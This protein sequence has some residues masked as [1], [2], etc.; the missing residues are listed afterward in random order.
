MCEYH[1]QSQNVNPN[2]TWLPKLFSNG[3]FL[4]FAMDV[5]FLR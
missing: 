3:A 5:C 2:Q 4:K 1:G